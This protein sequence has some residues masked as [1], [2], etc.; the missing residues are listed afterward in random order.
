MK[1]ENHSPRIRSLTN[2]S[3]NA[4]FVGQSAVLVGGLGGVLT[5]WTFFTESTRRGMFNRASVLKGDK[6]YEVQIFG[7]VTSTRTGVIT[8]P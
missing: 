4:W 1:S 7:A 5:L 6:Y 3:F 2:V 8:K